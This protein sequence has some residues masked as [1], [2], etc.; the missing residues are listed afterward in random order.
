[1]EAKQDPPN[2]IS[3]KN[4]SRKGADLKKF[5]SE[6]SHLSSY[7][8]IIIAVC[9]AIL[10]W[11]LLQ[12]EFKNVFKDS[13]S[14][15]ENVHKTVLDKARDLGKNMK[16]SY[17]QSAD[18]V[19]AAM[20]E[21]MDKLKMTGDSKKQKESAKETKDNI[22]DKT[23]ET[24]NNLKEKSQE[25]IN[26]LKEKS[27]E[28]QENLKDKSQ[29]I[30]DNLKETSQTTM[31][32]VKETLSTTQTSVEHRFEMTGLIEQALFTLQEFLS[33]HLAVEEQI[34][35]K[36]LSGAK[37]VVFLTVV[38]GGVGISGAVGTGVV[39]AR[40]HKGKWGGPCAI[41][42]A[43]VD[44]GFNIGIE[45]SDHII[46]LREDSAIRAFGSAGQLKLGL[47]ASI[48]AG[49]KGR[50]ASIGVHVG[51]KGYAATYAYSMAK[52]AYIG[53]S[54]EGQIITIR[55]DCNEQ[56]YGKPVEASKILE[57]SVKPPKDKN[58]QQIY[59]IL[60]AYAELKDEI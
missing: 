34:P 14:Y 8:G 53:L 7:N 17:Q 16:D 43:G 31:D 21:T 40:N 3:S 60:D 32:K 45:K 24:L 42:L 25:T 29:Q 10:L 20:Q 26:T 51:D 37:A 5:F 49:P 22:A 50:D 15:V 9:V 58:L 6:R 35:I 56:F 38:K 13:N 47:D 19:N 39:V 48:A 2:V 18:A 57:G 11:V 36:I 44:I 46:I 55:N 52:G 28:T 59:K 12:W 30:I 4:V 1:M 23:K 27:Q 33:P 54:L 41:L